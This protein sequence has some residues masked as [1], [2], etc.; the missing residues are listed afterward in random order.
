MMD[1]KVDGYEVIGW[2]ITV[3]EHLPHRLVVKTPEFESGVGVA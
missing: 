3:S 1:T 2:Y